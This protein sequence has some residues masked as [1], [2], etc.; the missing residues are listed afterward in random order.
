MLFDRPC[1][2]E[3]KPLTSRNGGPK[4]ERG[5]ATTN[6]DASP[7]GKLTGWQAADVLRAC[8]PSETTAAPC[9]MR[10]LAGKLFGRMT[11]AL[12]TASD[13]GRDKPR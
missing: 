10:L 7:A 5:F 6:R 4:R 11:D 1:N 9:G 13:E 3:V 12:A 2:I 8:P